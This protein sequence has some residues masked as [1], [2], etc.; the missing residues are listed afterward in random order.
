MLEHSI[1]AIIQ[2]I[3]EFLPISSSGHIL[4]GQELFDLEINIFL[5]I[6]LHAS[7]LLAVVLYYHKDI[8]TLVKDFFLLLANKKQQRGVFALQLGVATIITAGS[9][10]LIARFLQENLSL[11][12]VGVMLIITALMIF[13][14][15]YVRKTSVQ[16]FGWK[17]TVLVALAQGLAVIPGLSRSGTTIAYLIAA[18]IKRHEA[19]RISFLLAIPTIFGSLLFGLSESENVSRALSL[20]YGVLFII[21]FVTSLISIKLMNSW[22]HKYWRLFIPYCI[23]LGL[24]VLIFL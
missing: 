3:T 19:V 5:A 7:S 13:L 6:W 23:T 1:I 18:G 17:Q 21:G 22:V 9:G 16:N 2:G 12:L 24:G 14:A 15:E 20:E 10:L 8:F 4:I 11:N